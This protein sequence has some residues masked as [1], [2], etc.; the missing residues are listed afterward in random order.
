MSRLTFVTPILDC[1]G[2]RKMALAVV[3][4]VVLILSINQPVDSVS[5][6]QVCVVNM[7]PWRPKQSSLFAADYLLRYSLSTNFTVVKPFE[8]CPPPPIG[9]PLLRLRL[10]EVQQLTQWCLG[11]EMCVVINDGACNAPPK[12]HKFYNKW[13]QKHFCS[14]INEIKLVNV[15]RTTDNIL[16]DIMKRVQEFEPPPQTH[17]HRK[18]DCVPKNASVSPS[19][20]YDSRLR[21]NILMRFHYASKYDTLT[22]PLGPSLFSPAAKLEA[23]VLN[24]GIRPFMFNFI[25]PVDPESE[26]RQL[27]LDVLESTNWTVP[28]HYEILPIDVYSQKANE[29][30]VKAYDVMRTS[31]FTLAP[32]GRGDDTFRLWEA[33]EADS[34]PIVVGRLHNP[35][36]TWVPCPKSLQ[37][38]KESKPPFIFLDSWH[39]LP[40]FIHNVQEISIQ[41]WKFKLKV[42]KEHFWVSVANKID[43]AIAKWREHV[44]KG[45]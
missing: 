39:E 10:V 37:S 35:N 27:L 4:V 21:P 17:K 15:E 25:G 5:F 12:N 28:H 20:E 7:V 24:N 11:D 40:K 33:V 23:P 26:D 14:K 18:D 45:H 19:L 9:Q 8:R 44:Q 30:A 13:M 22:L 41:L 36:K 16:F 32:V 38:L 43:V 3:L 31:S 42:W 29:T 34:I 6:T 1:S 2:L